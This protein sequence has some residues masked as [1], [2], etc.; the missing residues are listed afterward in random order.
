MTLKVNPAAT[1]PTKT[2]AGPF[3][4]R[5]L[6]DYIVGVGSGEDMHIQP[7]KSVV[8]DR[9]LQ[10][11]VKGQRPAI[12]GAKDDVVDVFDFSAIFEDYGALAGIGD[13]ASDGWVSL[14]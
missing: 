12:S 7:W 5:K 11:W 13:D 4:S 1:A 8:T 3:A 2:T 6:V 14:D 9:L 10:W